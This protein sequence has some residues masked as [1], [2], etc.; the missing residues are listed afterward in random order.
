MAVPPAVMSSS[1]RAYNPRGSSLSRGPGLLGFPVRGDGPGGVYLGG[2]DPPVVFLKAGVR[3]GCPTGG[4]VLKYACVQVSSPHLVFPLPCRRPSV[5]VGDGARSWRFQ[6]PAGGTH[7]ESVPVLCSRVCTAA[8]NHNRGRRARGTDPLRS[9]PVGRCSLFRG[10]GRP[11]PWR[12]VWVGRPAWRTTVP[13][14]TTRSMKAPYRPSVS[15]RLGRSVRGDHRENR[16][17]QIAV[18]QRT[19]DCFPQRGVRREVA[20]SAGDP[21]ACGPVFM[22]TCVRVHN[23]DSGL[24]R[25]AAG[26]GR[27]AASGG[28]GLPACAPAFMRT[29]VRVRNRACRTVVVGDLRR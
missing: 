15:V 5:G 4:H 24:G 23:A 22:R 1:T 13:R 19:P 21:P 20:H 3:D 8:Y 16:P 9:G 12:G 26:R 10:D 2:R 27:G 29:C 6:V 7:S 25:L 28:C 18:Q 11:P 17:P 14:S